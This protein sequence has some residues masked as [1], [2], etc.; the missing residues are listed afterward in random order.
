MLNRNIY[1]I[2]Q[3]KMLLMKPGH[4]KFSNYKIM[5]ITLLRNVRMGNY[6]DEFISAQY[7]KIYNVMPIFEIHL[8]KILTCG[9]YKLKKIPFVLILILSNSFLVLALHKIN[10][11]SESDYVGTAVCGMCHNEEIPVDKRINFEERWEK[12]KHSIPN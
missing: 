1:W 12:I 2:T 5:L 4:D 7:K 10:Y 3:I 8:I 9:F 11:S 6:V